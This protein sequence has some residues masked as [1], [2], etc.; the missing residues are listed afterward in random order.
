MK[1]LVTGAT[2]FIGSNLVK[3]LVKRKYK[4]NCLCRDLSKTSDLLHPDINIFRGD[5]LNYNTIKTAISGCNGLFHMAAFTETWTKD[6]AD[7]Y[8]LNV[9]GTW[10]VLEAALSENVKDIVITSTAGVLGPSTSGVIDEHYK[11]EIPYFSKYE[12]TKQIAE[13]LALDYT[14]KG[15][16]IRI[17]NPTRVFGPGPL[18]ESNSVTRMI[19]LYTSGKWRFLPGNGES[20][21]NYVY[22]DDVVAGHIRVM[23]NGKSGE[24]YLLGGENISYNA[25]FALLGELTGKKVFSCSSPAFS[26]AICILSANGHNNDYRYKTCYHSRTSQEVQ[27]QFYYGLGQSCL[28]AGIQYYTVKRGNDEDTKVAE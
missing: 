2:G 1:V 15:L 3:E 13:D 26:Y 22:I 10:N 24:R 28:S 8:R 5:I 6:Q 25:F 9:A 14:S 19:R 12:E 21:G 23:E 27:L 20:I 7:I 4:I 17:V 18:N 11:R 16:N